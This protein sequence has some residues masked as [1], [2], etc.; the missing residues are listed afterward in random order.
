M[1]EIGIL[2]TWSDNQ[3][4]ECNGATISKPYKARCTID[5][6]HIIQKYSDVCVPTKNRS[7]WPRD[8]ARRESGSGDLVEQRLKQMMIGSVDEHRVEL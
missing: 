8:V 2:R 4:I 1:S 7:Q 3:S 6:Q 5:G